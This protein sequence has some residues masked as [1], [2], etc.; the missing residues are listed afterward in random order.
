MKTYR[1]LFV[2]LSSICFGTACSAQDS[3]VRAPAVGG[4]FYPGSAD[5]LKLA[6]D[7]CLEGALPP[8]AEKPIAIVCPHAGYV[9]SAQI[10]ADAFRQAKGHPYDLVVIL[11][12][13]HTAPG[14]RR[15]A[16]WPGKAFRTPL[17][18]VEIDQEVV[19]ALAAAGDL[20][21][22]DRQ[23][24]VREHSVEV[25]L[26]FV[27]RLFPGAKIV[28]AIIP[29]TGGQSDLKLCTD[30]G[31]ALARALK[32]KSALIVASSDLSHYPAY[33]DAVRADRKTLEAMAK[34]DPGELQSATAAKGSVD[35][36]DTCACGETPVM[37]AM[38]AAKALGAT[39]GNVLSY[40][41]SGDT[42]AGD[43]GRCV[44]YGAVSFD[45]GQAPGSR[46]GIEKREPA[47]E[48]DSLRPE[49]KKAL[50][51]FARETIDR[52][53]STDTAPLPRGFDPRCE[54]KR[55]AFV[56][57]KKRGELRGCIGHMSEDA[58]LCWTVGAMAIQAAFNDRR[59]TQLRREEI[60]EIEIE[61]S[62]L[63][64]AKP[65]AGPQDIVVGRDGVILRKS[66]RSAV[67]LPQ[68][69][70]EQG[71]S[72]EEMLEHL[73]QKAGLPAGSWKSGAE[74]LTFQAEVFGEAEPKSPPK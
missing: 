33:D 57:L 51:A 9:Y 27:Q 4:Q 56:T 11:G 49:D 71:W 35:G 42:V 47:K 23:P 70:P 18:S 65:V 62:V 1:T 6:V 66:G 10:A 36:L 25:Q 41:N 63:T 54:L 67:F 20:C 61:I 26:P 29:A 73:S 21:V 31:V 14:L 72:R 30:F 45:A 69:A 68:V 16:L 13:N 48:S 40:A 53:L 74:F 7:K 55:G 58:P 19:K 39:R 28:P 24:H 60:P 38:A 34:M 3:D 50:L 43:R 12:T 46:K 32:G 59:F 64:P 44:G 17:G 15:V 5:K 2:V 8:P 52:V 37:V 22:L